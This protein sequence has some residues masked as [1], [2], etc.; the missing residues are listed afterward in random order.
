M[1]YSIRYA[2]Y[3]EMLSVL[4]RPPLNLQD[5]LLQASQNVEV[6]SITPFYGFYL[7][8]HEWLHYS[9]QNHDPL[10][11]EM[12]EAMLIALDAP[13]IEADPKMVLYFT[14]AASPN[15][16]DLCRQSLSVAF[17]TTMLFQ[18]YIHLQNKVALLKHDKQFTMR[19]YK[20]LLK[21]AVVLH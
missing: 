10:V 20:T 8:P 6:A 16:E 18:T 4:K 5:L 1:K 3:E 12:N 2:V 14:I 21:E 7:Y 9:L 19:S 15:Y 13:T 11:A 17:K